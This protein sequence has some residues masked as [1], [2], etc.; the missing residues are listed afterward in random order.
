MEMRK[1]EMSEE[2]SREVLGPGPCNHLTSP[3]FLSFLFFF[4]IQGEYNIPLAPFSFFLYSAAYLPN[5]TDSLLP[6]FL[7][8]YPSIFSFSFFGPEI[9]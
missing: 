1:P 8:L 7:F 5:S 6:F 4:F 9:G 2:G 3:F